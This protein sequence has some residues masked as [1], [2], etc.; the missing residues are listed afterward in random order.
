[1]NVCIVGTKSIGA[2]STTGRKALAI[3]EQ[4]AMRL[5]DFENDRDGWSILFQVYDFCQV[6][7][8]ALVI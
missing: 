5:V 1:M 8:I 7:A 2:G 4:I 3:A 6:V